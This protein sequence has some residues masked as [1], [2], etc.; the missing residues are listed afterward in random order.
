ME[1]KLPKVFANPQSK[2]F[3]NNEKVYYSKEKN[4]LRF[5][6]Y[7]ETKGDITL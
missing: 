1:K 4:D 2:K 7:K 6:L 5:D 3:V